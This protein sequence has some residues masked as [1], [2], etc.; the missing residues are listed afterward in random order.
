MS[1][2]AKP[3]TSTPPGILLLKAKQNTLIEHPPL[4]GQ[5]EYSHRASCLKRPGRKPF[6]GLG[7]LRAF[8][9]LLDLFSTSSGLFVGVWTSSQPF[10]GLGPPR[11]FC[12][13][14]LGLRASSGPFLGPRAFPAFSGLLGLWA[15]RPSGPRSL[16]WALSR[17]S[18]SSFCGLLSLFP[19]FGLLGLSGPFVDLF[20]SSE[21][22]LGLF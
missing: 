1:Y 20:W 10:L 2:G 6:L 5:A 17:G 13:P 14:F 18:A 12:R 4:K 9:G 3:Y 16:F 11:A 7:P 8:S 22:L 19:A 21:P 15:C